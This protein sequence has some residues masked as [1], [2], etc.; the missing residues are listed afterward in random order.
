MSSFH[1]EKMHFLMKVMQH[2]HVYKYDESIILLVYAM[3]NQV[4]DID[5]IGIVFFQTF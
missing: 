4:L 3:N 5:G 1:N 2:Q